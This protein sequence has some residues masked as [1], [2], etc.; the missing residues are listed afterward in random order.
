MGGIGQNLQLQSDGF[1]ILCAIR[2]LHK[3]YAYQILWQYM[4]YFA[5]YGKKWVCQTLTI[6]QG[7]IER[8]SERTSTI[9]GT[10]LVSIWRGRLWWSIICWSIWLGMFT[11][12]V[13]A[14]TKTG[15]LHRREMRLWAMASMCIP[16]MFL[17]L[18]LLWES[19]SL[20]TSCNMIG[21]PHLIIP[22]TLFCVRMFEMYQSATEKYVIVSHRG[23]VN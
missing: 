18:Q 7:D 5:C 15:D 11:L 6:W 17:G 14:R 16:V 20:Q 8:G 9:S 2:A 13:T 23:K 22:P 3:A 19:L 4:S 10:Q 12:S 21:N 1:E